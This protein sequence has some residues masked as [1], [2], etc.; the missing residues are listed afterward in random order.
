LCRFRS[1][2]SLKSGGKSEIGLNFFFANF[3]VV[4]LSLKK[5]QIKGTPSLRAKQGKEENRRERNNQ[6]T[7]ESR[8]LAG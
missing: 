3:A 6:L 4:E 1:F 8:K 5:E 7:V 2:D